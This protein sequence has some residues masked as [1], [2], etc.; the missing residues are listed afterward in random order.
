M[1][2]EPKALLKKISLADNFGCLL[3]LHGVTTLTDMTTV[4]SD[5]I[6]EIIRNV[7]DG[8]YSYAVDFNDEKMREIF[9]GSKKILPHNF[10]IVGLNYKKLANLHSS[11]S[12]M[13]NELQLKIAK[14][15]MKVGS[16]RPLATED[17]VDDV[18]DADESRFVLVIYLSVIFLY[19]FL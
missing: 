11:A 14:Q 10:N 19:L 7:K 4:D 18:V 1:S 17:D 12:D 2:K 6:D 8:T 15:H 16:K 3:A 9:L 5:T 13:L